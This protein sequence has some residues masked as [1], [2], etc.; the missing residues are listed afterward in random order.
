M[1]TEP[2]KGVLGKD[3]PFDRS[4]E[5]VTGIRVPA[6]DICL[7]AQSVILT[8]AGPL[9]P[10]IHAD[11]TKR[12]DDNVGFREYN[13]IITVEPAGAVGLVSLGK[14]CWVGGSLG[15]YVNITIQDGACQIYR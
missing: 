7:A 10:G 5:S 15:Q 3:V 8:T 12:V 9:R 14:D 6:A 13:Y 11:L 1:G 2:V 4:V